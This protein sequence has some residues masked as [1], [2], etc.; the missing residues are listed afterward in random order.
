MVECIWFIKNRALPKLMPFVLKMTETEMT[1]VPRPDKPNVADRWNYF[2]YKVWLFAIFFY[3]L[4]YKQRKGPGYNCCSVHATCEQA[5]LLLH[6]LRI[7][8]VWCLDIK[9]HMNKGLPYNPIQ[10]NIWPPE[11]YYN[12]DLT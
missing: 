3:V 12:A 10:F 5:L 7:K 2:L 9:F 1:E 6:V 8:C 4:F 11:S